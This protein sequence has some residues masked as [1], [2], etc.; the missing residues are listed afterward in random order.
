MSGNA[1]GPSGRSIPPVSGEFVPHPG[2]LVAHLRKWFVSASVLASATSL[3]LHVSL[4]ALA[5]VVTV[6]LVSTHSDRGAPEGELILSLSPETELTEIGDASLDAT[7]P[8][9][10]TGDVP[11]PD[12]TMP[13]IDTGP[14][15]DDAPGSGPG[16]GPIGDGLGGAGGGD[17]GDGKGLG[18]GGAGGGASF[19]G[20][21]AKGSRF[22]YI[23]DVSGSMQ[24]AKMQAMK[25]ELG[26]SI[27]GLQ[28][29]MSFY[30]VLYSSDAADLGGKDRW[31]VATAA[32]KKWGLDAIYRLEAAGGTQ[33][34]SG[35]ERVFQIK[36]APDAIYFMTDGEFDPSVAD[37]IALHNKGSKK[38]PIHAMTFVNKGAEEVMRKI[39]TDSG[40]TYHHV[41]GP[42]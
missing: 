23:L 7:T 31:T 18:S 42:K 6:G 11:L 28:E 20:V 13:G 25:I 15:G 37:L 17:I 19:F 21:K 14:G 16:F 26:E 2:G 24:G 3:L 33:P 29:H 4:V 10:A 9:V 40:G 5:A 1:P 39:A 35:F 34:W 27:N 32:G 30:V 38:V 22:A 36:P 8:S 12:V 41:E